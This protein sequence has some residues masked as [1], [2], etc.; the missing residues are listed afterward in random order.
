MCQELCV[1]SYLAKISASEARFGWRNDK[2]FMA[3]EL[4]GPLLRNLD[5]KDG[6]YVDVGA[7]AGGAFSNTYH[8]DLP[9]WQGILIDPILHNVFNQKELR[10]ADHNHLIYAACVDK[11]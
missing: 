10:S 9:G 1:E 5:N 4:A 11:K 7:N 8:L 3:P 2:H 6:N